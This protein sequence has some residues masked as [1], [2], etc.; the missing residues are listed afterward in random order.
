MQRHNT[1]GKVI[2]LKNF[3]LE[4]IIKFSYVKGQKAENI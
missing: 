2:M 4:W 1:F 3:K